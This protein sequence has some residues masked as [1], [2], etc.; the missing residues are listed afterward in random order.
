MSDQEHYPV[1]EAGDDDIVALRNRTEILER[2]LAEIERVTQARLILAELKAESLKAGMIDLDGV[3]LVDLSGAKLNDQGEFE[4]AA[5]LVTELKRN[6]PWL[7]GRSSSSGAVP[8]VAQPPRQKFATEMTDEEY[9]T[10]RAA[11]LKRHY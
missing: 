1:A 5:E 7:F 10:A 6:K 11:L 9:R 3:K 8:P 4:Q 2:Q